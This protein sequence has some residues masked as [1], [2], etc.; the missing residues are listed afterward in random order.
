[1]SEYLYCEVSASLPGLIRI[2]GAAEDPR[3]WDQASTRL[4]RCRRDFEF[5][6][7]IKVR[8]AAAAEQA[9]REALHPY[10]EETLRSFHRFDPTEARGVAIGFIALRDPDPATAKQSP[11]AHLVDPRSASVM[12]LALAIQ[13]LH[14]SQGKTH[15]TIALT[16]AALYWIV[17]HWTVMRAQPARV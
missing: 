9:L 12:A 10:R 14:F 17:R 8:S 3:T 1:M 15:L 5:A 13:F 4:Q 16:V 11:I 2:G 6:W 7:V